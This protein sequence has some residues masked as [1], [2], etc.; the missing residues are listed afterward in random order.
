MSL[1]SFIES[2]AMLRAQTWLSSI[3]QKFRLKTY[4][5]APPLTTSHGL[6]GTAFDLPVALVREEA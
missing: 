2:S 3:S 4:I 1:T 5:K 6:T